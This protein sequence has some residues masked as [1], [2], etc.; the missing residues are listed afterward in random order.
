MP[1]VVSKLSKYKLVRAGLVSSLNMY[2][3]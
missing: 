1:R 2:V 3:I